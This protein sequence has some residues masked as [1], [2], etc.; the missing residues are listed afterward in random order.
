MS[1]TTH[2]EKKGM[3]PDPSQSG[4]E[5]G[6]TTD[7]KNGGEGSFR[8]VETSVNSRESFGDDY[9]SQQEDEI[10]REEAKTEKEGRTGKS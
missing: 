1:V 10:S 3:Q 7:S 5:P 6:S 8:N 9:E 2:E 4:N